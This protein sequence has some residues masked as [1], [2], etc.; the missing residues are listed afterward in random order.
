MFPAD[1][2]GLHA[3]MDTILTKENM[4]GVLGLLKS[5]MLYSVPSV[6]SGWSRVYGKYILTIYSTL[7]EWHFENV[8]K[9]LFDN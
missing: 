3:P 8:K 2:S 9:C 4:P 7:Q 1:A 5:Y 6:P